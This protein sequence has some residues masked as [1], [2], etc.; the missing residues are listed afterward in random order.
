MHP[1]AGVCIDAV[2]V[3][4]VIGIVVVKVDLDVLDDVG[5]VLQ[6]RRDAQLEIDQPAVADVERV[7]FVAYPKGAVERTR[8]QVC[9]GELHLDEIDA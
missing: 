7:K 1:Q 5:P 8:F 3:C 2:H 4:V 6:S 9:L